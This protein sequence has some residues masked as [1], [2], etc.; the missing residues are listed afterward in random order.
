M[1]THIKPKKE[2]FIA[3]LSVFA[4]TML[5]NIAVTWI[6]RAG[7][8]DAIQDQLRGVAGTASELTN[9]DLHQTI[10]KPE[11][12]ESEDYLNVQAPYRQM[13]KANP[14]L[15]YIYTCVLREGKI[16]FIIDTQQP[17]PETLK[18]KE[19]E[20]KTTANVMEEYT[21]ATAFLQQALKDHVVTIEDH[22]YTDE[23]GTV[24]SA[25]APIYNS[26]HEFIGI[27]GTDID[28]TDYNMRMR[29]VWIAFS[30]GLL[31]A[32]ALSYA[33]YVIV[34]RIRTEH[35]ENEVI[36]QKRLEDMQDFNV[37]MEKIA[38]R[39]SVTSV[40]IKDMAGGIST[41]THSGV[42]KIEEAKNLIHGATDR[43][44]S[45]SLVCNQLVETA[46]RLHGESKASQQATHDAVMQL[47]GMD[48]S[49]QHLVA[50]TRNISE[51]V[52]MINTITE[53]I[54]LLALNATI[55]AARA[56]EAGKGFAV[57]A[58]EVKQLSQQTAVATQ[59]INSYIEE[60]QRASETVVTSFAGI[61]ERIDQ[62][63]ERMVGAASAIDTQ[64][65]LIALIAADVTGTTESA[66]TVERIVGAVTDIARHVEEKTEN[67]HAA[68][69]I[70]SGQNRSLSTKV[71][72]FIDKLRIDSPHTTPLPFQRK[73]GE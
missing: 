26:A 41:M 60:M 40:E 67:L 32:G 25:Y 72:D 9:G 73:S 55:E 64:K 4:I 47:R 48:N 50:T 28:A 44:A 15:R 13:L 18:L 65:E 33:V 71:S 6:A 24:I 53:K 1:H 69:S 59:K 2:A 54:D 62:V 21:A 10:T 56:G 5:C 19:S 61:T 46:T 63:N 66:S 27:V 43:M 52:G 39:V 30:V 38:A 20:R 22:P 17:S 12:K 70:L 51:I 11:Q 31:L 34:F 14:D 68:S 42:T 7:M 29:Y 3:A 57:V 16:Y 58:D 37:Q 36:R 35:A 23:W 45:I 8:L 49:S